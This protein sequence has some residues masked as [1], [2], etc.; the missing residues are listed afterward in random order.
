MSRHKTSD[1]TLA[2]SR[3]R[4]VTMSSEWTALNPNIEYNNNNNTNNNNVEQ[5][6]GAVSVARH[7]RLEPRT[8]LHH[9]AQHRWPARVARISAQSRLDVAARR[10][11]DATLEDEVA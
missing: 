10:K 6:D 11:V 4:S 2:P 5:V 1:R 3:V 9:L 7:G 8:W